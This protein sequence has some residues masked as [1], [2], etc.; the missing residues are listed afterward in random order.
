MTFTPVS[1][2]NLIQVFTYQNQIGL[3]SQTREMKYG[4]IL[5]REI[6]MSLMDSFRNT[7]QRTRE[8]VLQAELED[9]SMLRGQRSRSATQVGDL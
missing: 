9:L 7:T 5:P 4:K 3:I 1:S 6:Y 2:S 8:V